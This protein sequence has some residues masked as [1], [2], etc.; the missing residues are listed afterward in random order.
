V[1]PLWR[2]HVSAGLFPG[3]FWL[4]GRRAVVQHAIQAE[5]SIDTSTLLRGL[6][7]MLDERVDVLRKGSPLTLIVSDSIAA[8]ILLPW[9]ENLY[10]QAELE[11]YARLCFEKKGLTVD[12]KWIVRTAAHHYR[13]P[14]FAYAL[15][16]DW[17]NELLQAVASR[18]LQLKRVLPVSA[19]AFCGQRIS[20]KK[21]RTL[22]LLREKL[23]TS[24]LT[25]SEGR[26]QGV[27]VEPST[28]SGHSPYIRLLRRIVGSPDDFVRC[29][30]WSSEVPESVKPISGSS[31]CLPNAEIHL[32]R[33]NVWS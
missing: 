4:E 18:G 23:R 10:R 14:G 19:A 8:T 11:T 15:P 22:L 12:D 25:Y 1:S 30:D 3:C 16:R 28:A 24:A 29:F 26:F 33:R 27:D 7:T 17:V 5:P 6:E 2:D 21:G 13:A 20:R 31:L 32:L 9:Q